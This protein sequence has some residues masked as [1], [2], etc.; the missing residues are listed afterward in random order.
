MALGDESHDPWQIEFNSRER[1]IAAGTAFE[2]VN[3]SRCH[4][5]AGGRSPAP[6]PDVFRGLLRKHSIP[7]KYDDI[8]REAILYRYLQ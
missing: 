5:P 2:A 7:S 6:R 8:C 1:A 4:R 3:K